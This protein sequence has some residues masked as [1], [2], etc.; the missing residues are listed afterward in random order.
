MA[1]SAGGFDGPILPVDTI[2]ENLRAAMVMGFPVNEDEQPS[3]YFDSTYTYTYQDSA[4]NPFDWSAS[5]ATGISPGPV[6]VLC[7]YEFSAPLGRQGAHETAVG[8]F[9]PTTLVITMLDDEFE[10][11]QGFRYCTVGP[12]DEKW[13]FRFYQPAIGLG[14]MTVYQITCTAEEPS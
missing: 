14:G 12:S 7:A 10:S 9:N 2:K 8:Q 4:G 11:I 13:Y 6:Q 3:F 5:P 1:E